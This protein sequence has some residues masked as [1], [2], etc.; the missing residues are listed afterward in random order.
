MYIVQEKSK[1][2]DIPNRAK[3]RL[4]KALEPRTLGGEHNFGFI[5]VDLE[6]RKNIPELGRFVVQE[7]D[8]DHLR[9]ESQP[10]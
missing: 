7:R 8:V 10:K 9:A 6:E 1:G 5:K 3:H 2:P 4:N